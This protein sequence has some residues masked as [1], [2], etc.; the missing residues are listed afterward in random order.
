M[1]GK[2]AGTVQEVLQGGLSFVE[3][4]CKKEGLSFT[5]HQEKEFKRYTPNLRD[6]SG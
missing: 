1:P 6:H 3:D 5:F 2:F 4:W